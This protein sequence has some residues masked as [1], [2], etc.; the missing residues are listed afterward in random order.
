MSATVIDANT[1]D[2]S[3]IASKENYVT[4]FLFN[5]LLDAN[6]SR[7]R[8]VDY[9]ENMKRGFDFGT[10]GFEE[11][12]RPTDVGDTSCDC[13][14]CIDRNSVIACELCG[15]VGKHA[16]RDSDCLDA[17]GIDSTMYIR[18]TKDG[19]K[20]ADTYNSYYSAHDDSRMVGFVPWKFENSKKTKFLICDWCVV[21]MLVKRRAVM[22]RV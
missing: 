3:T 10:R 16:S 6:D 11:L 14:W 17:D 2:T 21:N 22:Y 20:F 8:Y 1:L 15:L 4:W 5:I 12:K 13:E 9:K 19:M 18:T 7:N